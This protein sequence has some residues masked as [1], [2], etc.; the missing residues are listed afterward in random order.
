MDLDQIQEGLSGIADV[1]KESMEPDPKDAKNWY[2]MLPYIQILASDNFEKFAHEFLSEE[3]TE[4][5]NK[6]K[7][8][9]G[10]AHL[11]YYLVEELSKVARD[12]T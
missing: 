3:P 1:V 9:K 10:K 6:L 11:E 8:M 12:R 4:V 5:T 7:K 2:T